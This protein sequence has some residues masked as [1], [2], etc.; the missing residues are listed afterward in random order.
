MTTCGLQSANAGFTFGVVEEFDYGILQ[1]QSLRHLGP[2]LTDVLPDEP[3][4]L[5]TTNPGRSP[6][7]HQR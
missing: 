7:V 6:G 1:P 2:P 3:L 4:W 5:R